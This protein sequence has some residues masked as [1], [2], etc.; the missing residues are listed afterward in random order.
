[1]LL[2]NLSSLRVFV[3]EGEENLQATQGSV[4]LTDGKVPIS[5]SS[6]CLCLFMHCILSFGL[7]CQALAVSLAYNLTFPRFKTWRAKERV[8]NSSVYLLPQSVQQHDVLTQSGKSNRE[9]FQWLMNRAGQSFIKYSI[10]IRRIFLLY[11]EK[12]SDL[13]GLLE[14]NANALILNKPRILWDWM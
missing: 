5:F 12:N 9:S 3:V 14:I 10:T 6:F 11:L 7:A 1:M 4:V 13:F 8:M 2:L